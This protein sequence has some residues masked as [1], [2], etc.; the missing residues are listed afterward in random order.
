[1]LVLDGVQHLDD[2]AAPQ[3]VDRL[4]ANARPHVL[5]EDALEFLGGAQLLADMAL[6][7][8]VEKGIDRVCLRLD[9]LAARGLAL[10][11]W[12]AIG[13]DFP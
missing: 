8:R 12:I 4:G 5:V 9:R 3:V 10:L 13:R 7:E 11:S 1:M 2:V 6:E